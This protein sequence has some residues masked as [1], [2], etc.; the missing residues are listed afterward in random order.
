MHPAL[1]NRGLPFADEEIER[2]RWCVC[3]I[4]SHW[5]QDGRTDQEA[6]EDEKKPLAARAIE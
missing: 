2:G 5:F 4:G 1:R 6:R 3:A